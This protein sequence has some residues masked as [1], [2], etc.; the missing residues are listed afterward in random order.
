MREEKG[1]WRMSDQKF[2]RDFSNEHTRM[3]WGKRRDCFLE[4]WITDRI[5]SDESYELYSFGLKYLE[6]GVTPHKPSVLFQNHWKAGRKITVDPSFSSS[7][8]L[9]GLNL[10]W[11][12]EKEELLLVY[13][14]LQPY[15]KETTNI[16]KVKPRRRKTFMMMGSSS[17]GH[18][19]FKNR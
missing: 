18:L 15:A 7:D 16:K 13:I 19:S 14:F 12:S 5:M 10:K 1:G 3:C 4:N 8:W 9:T 6:T 2:Q 11:D 17:P